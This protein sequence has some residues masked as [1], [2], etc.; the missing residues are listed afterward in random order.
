MKDVSC[1][2]FL[3]KDDNEIFGTYNNNQR[4]HHLLSSNLFSRKVFFLSD[5]QRVL[6]PH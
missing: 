1:N 4:G 5:A 2:I 6:L 3:K